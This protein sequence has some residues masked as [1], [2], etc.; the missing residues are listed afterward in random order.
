MRRH[1]KCGGRDAG[2][3]ESKLP[4]QCTCRGAGLRRTSW[5]R[6][7]DHR[8]AFPH[9]ERGRSQD[10]RGQPGRE[11]RGPGGWRG[12]RL[13]PEHRV[14]LVP[15]GAGDSRLPRCKQRPCRRAQSAPASDNACWRDRGP[16]RLRADVRG[17]CRKGT[18]FRIPAKS[19]ARFALKFFFAAAEFTQPVESDLAKLA[20]CPREGVGHV[21][22]GDSIIFRKLLVRDLL[23]AFQVV[24]FEQP[25]GTRAFA[26]LAQ[27]AQVL[28]GE[29]KKAPHPF[30]LEELFQ[31]FRRG[32]FCGSDRRG[33][34]FFFCRSKIQSNMRDA[35]AALLTPAG[36][37]L[38][39]DKAVHANAQVS[40]Q[41]ALVRI[42]SVEKLSFEQF[43]KKS[44]GK[45]PSRFDRTIPSPADVFVDGPPVRRAK[46]FERSLALLR[47][48]AARR[49]DHGAPRQRKAIPAR[50]KIILPHWSA[51]PNCVGYFEKSLSRKNEADKRRFLPNR[52]GKYWRTED[53][54]TL[55]AGTPRDGADPSAALRQESWRTATQI[56]LIK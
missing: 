6:R 40:S 49:L 25:E 31:G 28:D 44:L 13:F 4:T 54:G 19:G 26:V 50:L 46:R 43:R 17:R 8:R 16:P 10:A 1:R 41:A 45:I 55:L 15:H 37:V 11:L 29:G 52:C 22:H 47:V 48:N 53:F 30:F 51:C 9:R 33:A 35:T 24:R 27:F 42:K 56:V 39:H 12:R 7:R 20:A 18:S 36:S 3:Q 38:V 23:I 14:L 21:G 5:C 34:Q 32:D 2:G